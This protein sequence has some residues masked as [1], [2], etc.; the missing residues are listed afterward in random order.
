LFSAWNLVVKTLVAK[1]IKSQ[2][3]IFYRTI[4]YRC[5]KTLVWCPCVATVYKIFN[6]MSVYT[7]S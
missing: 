2:A 4:V 5:F 1:N 3:L 6:K 7:D